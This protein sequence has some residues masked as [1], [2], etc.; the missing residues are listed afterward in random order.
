MHPHCTNNFNAPEDV[1][2]TGVR[3]TSIR[4]T[5][6]YVQ[7]LI[8]MIKNGTNQRNKMKQN[9]VLCSIYHL[10][11]TVLLGLNGSVF[12]KWAAFI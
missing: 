7:P 11:T 12:E 1:V 2:G 10:G 9:T 5:C 8:D 6:I 3:M 4:V